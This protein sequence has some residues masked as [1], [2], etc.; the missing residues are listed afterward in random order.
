MEGVE[1][2]TEELTKYGQIHD[3][4]LFEFGKVPKISLSDESER[5][6]KLKVENDVLIDDD[7]NKLVYV[8]KSIFNNYM[9]Y[10]IYTLNNNMY[11][12]IMLK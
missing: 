11:M 9:G 4:F 1:N 10:G 5:T 7:I 3:R 8:C 12:L 6:I 2:M